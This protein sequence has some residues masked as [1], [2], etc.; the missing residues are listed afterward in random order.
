[1]RWPER[2]LGELDAHAKSGAN[3]GRT[4]ADEHNSARSARQARVAVTVLESL[5]AEWTA[6]A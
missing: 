1:M 5:T 6:A 3:S 2:G 4:T